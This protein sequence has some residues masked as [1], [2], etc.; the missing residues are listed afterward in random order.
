[1]SRLYSRDQF[2][3]AIITSGFPASNLVQFEWSFDGKSLAY[4]TGLRMQEIILLQ[5]SK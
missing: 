2:E 3:R 5:N 1:M 4:S